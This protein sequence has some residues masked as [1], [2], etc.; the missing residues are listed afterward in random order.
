MGNENGRWQWR[1]EIEM[2]NKHVNAPLA[3]ICGL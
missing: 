2:G 3:F 1:V